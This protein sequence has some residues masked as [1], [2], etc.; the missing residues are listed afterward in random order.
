MT[1]VRLEDCAKYQDDASFRLVEN[2]IYE[3]LGDS[4]DTKFRMTI[5]FQ[6]ED[7]ADEQYPMEDILDKY[8]IH[9]SDFFEDEEQAPN[10]YKHELAGDLSALQCAKEIIGKKIYNQD[11]RDDEGVV[12]VNLVIE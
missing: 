2:G 6:L 12:R 11:F 9:V 5:S 8:L 7:D 10:H 4:E 1:N 3:D